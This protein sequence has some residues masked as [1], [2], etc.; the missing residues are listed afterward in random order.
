VTHAKITENQINNEFTVK[1]QSR[2]NSN[3][4]LDG[5]NEQKVLNEYKMGVDSSNEESIN[6]RSED[7]IREDSVGVPRFK[8]NI[9]CPQNTVFNN[10]KFKQ[11][12]E[13]NQKRRKNNSTLNS[14][15]SSYLPSINSTKAQIYDGENLNQNLSNIQPNKELLIF[16]DK[17]AKMKNKKSFFD[18][19]SIEIIG[20]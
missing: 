9:L 20:F 15:D 14:Q 1:P 19:S 2:R 3:V 4:A 16:L 5:I 8:K 17:F 12:F 7:Q 10:S 6:D 18:N 13:Q 11:V